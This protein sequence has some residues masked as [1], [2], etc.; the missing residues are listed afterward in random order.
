MK[1]DFE[2][3]IE[4]EVTRFG[5]LTLLQHLQ[6]GTLSME[7]YHRLLLRVLP[8]VYESAVT[9]SL[10]ASQIA[11]PC[12]FSIRSYL[13]S[14]AE[15]EKLHWQWILNDLKNTGYT[16]PSPSLAPTCTATAAYIAFNYYTAIRE[17]IGR[18]AIA[19]FL[20]SVGARY[21]NVCATRLCSVLRLRS[22]QATFFFGHGDTDVGHTAEILRALDA[23]D[24][25]SEEWD[26]MCFIAS[27]ASDLYQAIYASA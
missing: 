25:S 11:D 7:D 15:E 21:G 19:A 14:H 9:F 8:Q 13:M 6:S 20:E 16:G 27:V 24:L 22:D 18:L 26:R 10:A 1:R 12:R 17:P 5:K 23:V 3:R 4:E 2:A